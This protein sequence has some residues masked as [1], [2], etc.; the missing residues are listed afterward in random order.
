MSSAT[1]KQLSVPHKML[2][3]YKAKAGTAAEAAR[4][5]E[6]M[7]EAEAKEVAG[8]AARV[9]EEAG[10]AAVGWGAMAWAEVGSV[11]MGWEAK[12]TE[13]AG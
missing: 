10:L 4:G 9:K 7:V 5:V 1:G 2:M 11:A 8:P 6:G 3:A 12:A 13:E